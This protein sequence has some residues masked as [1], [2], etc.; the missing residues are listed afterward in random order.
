MTHLGVIV[1]AGGTGER[2]GRTDK[3]ALQVDGVSLLDGVL[4]A[5][6]A[7]VRTVVVGEPRPTVRAVEWTREE[8][9]GTGPLAG[10]LAGVE[11]LDPETTPLTG[12]FATDLTA[13]GVADVGRLVDA[14]RANPEADAALFVDADGYRQPLAAVYRTVTLATTLRSLQPLPGLPMRALAKELTLVEVPDLGASADCD[15]PEQLAALRAR[16]PR[17]SRSTSSS[18]SASSSRSEG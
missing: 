11:V 10:L 5:T 16:S 17:S 4:Q 1:L 14:L 6:S 12:V 15:T 7:A 2:L 9:P 18:C 3:G 8:P 13:L